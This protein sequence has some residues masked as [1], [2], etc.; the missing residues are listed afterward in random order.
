[1]SSTLTGRSP[2]RTSRNVALARPGITR[3]VSR[4]TS[5]TPPAVTSAAK[6]DVLDR[7]A[8][9]DA[10]VGPRHHVVA[11]DGLHDRPRAGVVIV[12]AEVDDLAAHRADGQRHAELLA[13]P[14]PSTRRPR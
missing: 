7:R 2:T 6:P 11:V 8:D 14:G 3:N 1:M 5:C 12:D 4:S 13:R 9:R 10:R